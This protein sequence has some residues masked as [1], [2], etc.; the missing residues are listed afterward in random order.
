MKRQV[1]EPLYN[2]E[3]YNDSMRGTSLIETF[4]KGH[5]WLERLLDD[6]LTVAADPPEGLGLNRMTFAN[7]LRLCK[8]FALLPEDYCQIFK[9][10]NSI[11]NK[12]AHELTAEIE[13]DITQ[14][15][16]DG[17]RHDLRSAYEAM[18]DGTLP[19]EFDLPQGQLKR[20]FIAMIIAVGYMILKHEYEKTYRPE[21]IGLMAIDVAEE[22]LDRKPISTTE[23]YAR[24]KLPYPPHPRNVLKSGPPTDV[25]WPPPFKKSERHDQT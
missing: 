23:A 16:L 1:G 7:K 12:L 18:D 21:I 20:W 6:F 22:V 17:S 24:M 25:D 14:T 3:H 10:V 19:P 15:L 4:L 11:R 5:L 8:A 13:N 9:K 2:L